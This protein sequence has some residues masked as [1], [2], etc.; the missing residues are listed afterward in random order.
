MLN[1]TLELLT[2]AKNS[3]SARYM[4][5]FRRAFQRYYAL[6][7]PDSG[8]EYSIDAALTVSA[9]EQGVTRDIGF[10]SAGYRDLVALCSRMAM[11]ESMYPDVKPPLILDD[12]FVNLD[13]AKSARAHDFLAEAAKEYQILYFSCRS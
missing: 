2:A 10:L 8:R 5:P 11:L 6:I 7:D 4:A 3:L 13:S 12:P 1:K 9:R